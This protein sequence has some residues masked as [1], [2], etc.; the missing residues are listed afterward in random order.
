[1][2]ARARAHVRERERERER[3]RDRDRERQRERESE[4][5]REREGG[6][7]GSRTCRRR[8]GTPAS[9][10]TGPTSCSERSKQAVKSTGQ[11]YVVIS[12][13]SNLSGRSGQKRGRPSS[14]PSF[15]LGSRA[16][17]HTHAHAH[18]RT[19]TRTRTTFPLASHDSI[20]RAGRGGRP[21]HPSPAAGRGE[22]GPGR[23]LMGWRSWHR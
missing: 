4:R 13:W 14:V 21:C 15:T 1:V 19:R 6:G 5:E 22:C 23:V 7:G 11:I 3:E 17:A 2:R 12:K 18:A 9:W 20:R 10:G 8:A 16:R